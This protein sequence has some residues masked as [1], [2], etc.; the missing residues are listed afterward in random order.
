MGTSGDLLVAISTSGR[1]PNI[2]AAAR[3]AKQKAMKVLSLT[4]PG[5]SDL[6]NLADI[7]INAPG[8]STQ[9]I[10]EAH[11]VIIH[12][13]CTLLEDIVHPA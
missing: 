11:G 6:S 3:A 8:S 5:Q 2:I 7:A 13:L 9:L 10:Q 12:I 4:G 1:S